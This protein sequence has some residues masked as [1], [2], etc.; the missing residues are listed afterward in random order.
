MNGDFIDQRTYRAF[1]AHQRHELRTPLTAILGYGEMLL[2]DIAATPDP[3][4]FLVELRQMYTAGQQ[5]WQLVNEILDPEVVG[6]T[7]VWVEDWAQYAN[8]IHFRLRH[9][10][11]V[12]WGFAEILQERSTAVNATHLLPDLQHIDQ[13]C[14]QFLERL[15]ALVAYPQLARGEQPEAPASASLAMA[16]DLISTL[17]SIEAHTATI[18]KLRGHLLVVDDALGV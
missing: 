14:Q 9:P 1:L 8:Q 2:E 6:E 15:D 13:A 16:T 10:L 5:L 18:A 17:R 4:H 3:H 11:N 12:V 7:A